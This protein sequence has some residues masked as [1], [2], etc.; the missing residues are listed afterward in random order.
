VGAVALT[1]TDERPEVR[2]KVKE[3]EFESSPSCTLF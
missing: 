1:V 3:L 2:E